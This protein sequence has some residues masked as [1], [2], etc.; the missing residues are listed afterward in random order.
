MKH[1]GPKYLHLPK[2]PDEM[3]EKIASLE[4]KFGVPQAYGLIDRMHGPIKRPTLNSQDFFHYKQ[5]F[6][7]HFCSGFVQ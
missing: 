2:T 6:S 1:L 3:K 4:V 7:V 5:F